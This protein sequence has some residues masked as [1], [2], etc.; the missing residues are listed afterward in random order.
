MAKSREA[1]FA[2]MLESE[3]LTKV[4]VTVS[5]DA[6]DHATWWI[7]KNLYPEDVFS[8]ADLEKWATANGYVKGG[9][10]E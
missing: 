1:A 6:L 9:D 4:E 5:K 10:N 2:S 3:N 7:A 8:T